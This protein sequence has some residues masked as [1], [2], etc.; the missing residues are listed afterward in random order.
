MSNKLR[1]EIYRGVDEATHGLLYRHET[2]R[3]VDAILPIIAREVAAAK[4][5]QRDLDARISG[6]YTW[7]PMANANHGVV[8]AAR[9][10]AREIVK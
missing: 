6:D 5:E 4:V 7:N 9:I 2:M 1:G 3:I 8:I 10:S